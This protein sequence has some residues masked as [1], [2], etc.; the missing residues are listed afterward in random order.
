MILSLTGLIWWT[1]SA[2]D[3]A[4]ETRRKSE[5]RLRNQAELMDHAR[6]ALIVHELD[7]AIRFWNRGAAALYRWPAAEALGQRIHV[8]LRTEGLPADHEVHLEHTG[9]WEGEL[10]HWT[11]DN[12]RTI[13]ESSKTAIRSEDG[14]LLILE[15]NRDVTGHKQAEEALHGAN[16]ELERRVD[17]IQVANKA[18][19][20]SR[21]A[22]RVARIPRQCDLSS[23]RK[24][25]RVARSS[26]E[27]YKNLLYRSER[28]SSQ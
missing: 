2:L 10:I 8:L 22:A 28:R 4:D 20:D 3:R 24:R 14:H 23:N 16:T 25:S 27:V 19:Q 1:A 9:H 11:R 26:Y 17:E 7:G 21:R 18:L 13:V 5:T 6:E 12:R 15:S